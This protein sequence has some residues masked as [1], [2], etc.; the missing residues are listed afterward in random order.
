MSK[1]IGQRQVHHYYFKDGLMDFMAGWILGNTQLGGLSVGEVYDSFNRI[2]NGDPASWVD[3]FEANMRYQQKMVDERL[4]DGD[5]KGAAMKLLA[6]SQ[7][8][9]AAAS[10]CDPQSQRA[11]H[12]MATM[13]TSF[14][15]YNKLAG[16]SLVDHTFGYKGKK[17]PGYVTVP[18]KTDVPLMLII[19]GG[20][21]FREDLY[22]FGGKNAISHGYN[23]VMVD[24]PGQGKTPYQGLHFGQGTIDAISDVIDQVQAMGH[25]GKIVVMAY[26]GGGYFA[27]KSI[28]AEKRID[29]LIA[30]TPVVNMKEVVLEAIPSL[31]AADMTSF[32]S[33]AS[34]RLLTAF[35]KPSNIAFK[36]YA[37]QFGPN[38]IV[39]FLAAMD[40]TKPVNTE[41]ITIPVLGIVGLSEDAVSERQAK[42]IVTSASKRFPESRLVTFPRESGADAHCQV[43]NLAWGQHFMFGWLEEIK[44]AP[45]QDNEF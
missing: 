41:K 35:N 6:L 2:K 1:D 4:E 5:D 30:S 8:S 11:K 42:V 39:D 15:Q 37:W 34:M 21:S 40:I 7:A 24:L 43:N 44:I 45:K 18:L 16:N 20:D 10:F 26:S 28:E 3:A 19:G 32:L 17:L 25:R 14:Q 29:A 23:V 27:C 36:K 22:F 33:R 9:R 12:I 31:L 38:G 13:E